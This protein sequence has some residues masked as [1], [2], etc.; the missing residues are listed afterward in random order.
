MEIGQPDP[1][2]GLMAVET[3]E[4]DVTGGPSTGRER[5]AESRAGS[6]Q[7]G[8]AAAWLQELYA[9][10][11][12]V[13]LL[14]VGRTGGEPRN[15]AWQRTVRVDEVCTGRFLADLT[16]R[17]ERGWDI[18]ASVNPV[19]PGSRDRTV[20]E[21]RRLQLDLDT[22]GDESLRTLMRDCRAGKLPHPAVVVRTSPGRWQVL[23]HLEPT[24][25]SPAGAEEVN[26]RLAARY[27]GDPAVI[28][29]KRVFRLPGFR[30]SKPGRG[31]VTAVMVPR[32]RFDPD[33][34]GREYREPSSFVSL[35]RPRADPRTASGVG[36]A[37][38]AGGRPCEV[39]VRGQ[40]GGG[41]RRVSRSEE[42]WHAVVG[43]L[44]EGVPPQQLIEELA[45]HRGDKPRPREYAERTVVRA[46]RSVGVR[47]PSVGWY[48]R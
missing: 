32:S 44:R 29:V 28:D 33:G 5:A 15:R 3:S 7:A 46:C 30:N 47:P 24:S 39:D 36:Q 16:R 26:S 40:A 41:E 25:W 31:G 34:R 17:N 23:W 9:L 43:F 10:D 27:G 48:V 13:A 4:R 14:A 6:G 20:S 42:D 11:E 1:D 8:A 38:E 35:R 22:D 2:E 19:E 21:V 45:R 37:E 18:Y 12:S